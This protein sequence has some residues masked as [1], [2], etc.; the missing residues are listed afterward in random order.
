MHGIVDLSGH[1]RA[2]LGDAEQAAFI[3]SGPDVL[4]A[5]ITRVVEQRLAAGMRHNDRRLGG[6]DSIC[7]GAH[8][9]VG[10]VDEHADVVHL[11]DQFMAKLRETRTAGLIAAGT[12]PVLI[13]VGDLTGAHPQFVE[14]IDIIQIPAELCGI[15]EQ[16]KQGDLA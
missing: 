16:V 6:G 8:T 3:G 11:R 15:L 12:G 13:V 14:P 4:I 1:K 5:G 7:H 9:G 2:H 10:Q